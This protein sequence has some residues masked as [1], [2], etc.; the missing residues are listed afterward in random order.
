VVVLYLEL[1]TTVEFR[2]FRSVDQVD[3]TMAEI[4]EQMDVAAEISVAIS[5]PLSQDGLAGNKHSSIVAQ[6]GIKHRI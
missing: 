2:S 4:Q 5:Q 3:D 6:S 1:N